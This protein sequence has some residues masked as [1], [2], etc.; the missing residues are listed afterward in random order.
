MTTVSTVK[1]TEWCRLPKRR[2]NSQSS[3]LRQRDSHYFMRRRF[4]VHAA[5]K[6]KWM[7]TEGKQLLRHQRI[8]KK[9][10]Q[11]RSSLSIK[12]FKHSNRSIFSTRSSTC[13]RWTI[14]SSARWRE[15]LKTV[16]TFTFWWTICS[17]ESFS[18]FSKKS[19]G[20]VAL[21]LDFTVPKS[22]SSSSTCMGKIWSTGI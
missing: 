3:S 17:T 16:A 11:L 9:S 13:Q 14:G 20:W 18:M 4:L 2:Q 12:S 21:L 8:A 5:W 22:S 6:R 7:P 19:E 1:M 15:L 10:S